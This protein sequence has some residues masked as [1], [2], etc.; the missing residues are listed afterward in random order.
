MMGCFHEL[1]KRVEC[2]VIEL[3]V[4]TSTFFPSETG[5]KDDDDTSLYK[6]AGFALLSCIQF[7]QHRLMWKKKLGVSQITAENYQAE[8]TILK[9]LVDLQKMICHLP[10]KYR[11]EDI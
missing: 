8:L 3:S 9:Q 6:L 7:R 1:L 5:Y 11:I 10:L 2:Q 4:S